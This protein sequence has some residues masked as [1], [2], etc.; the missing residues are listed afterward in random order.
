MAG[1]LKVRSRQYQKSTTTY[2]TSK[3]VG[4]GKAVHQTRQGQ[5]G[6]ELICQTEESMYISGIH[7]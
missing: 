6:Q 4:Q 5:G 7:R 3:P 1:R 2:N